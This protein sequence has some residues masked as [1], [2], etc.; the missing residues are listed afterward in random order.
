[1][2]QILSLAAVLTLVLPLF[3]ANAQEHPQCAKDKQCA[4]KT[5]DKGACSHDAKAMKASNTGSHHCTGKA[6]LMKASNTKA[7]CADHCVGKS[8]AECMAKCNG[9]MTE[10]CAEKC[11]HKQAST[12]NND[13]KN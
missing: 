7:D 9:K 4:T 12:E 2:K 3:I 1:M 5:M 8:K 10:K 13:G 11:A 6:T